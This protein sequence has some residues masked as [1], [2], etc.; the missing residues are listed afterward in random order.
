MEGDALGMVAGRRRDD[1][2]G[3][4]FGWQLAEVIE[5]AAHLE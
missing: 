5:G 2:G 4:R 3:A 1:A